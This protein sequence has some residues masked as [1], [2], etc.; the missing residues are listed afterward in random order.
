MMVANQI[1]GFLREKWLNLEISKIR[2]IQE[3]I[4]GLTDDVLILICTN[5]AFFVDVDGGMDLGYNEEMADPECSIENRFKSFCSRL[6]ESISSIIGY[7]YGLKHYSKEYIWK[8]KCDDY[9]SNDVSTYLEYVVSASKEYQKLLN[10]FDLFT[11]LTGRTD[12][13][14]NKYEALIDVLIDMKNEEQEDV[15][16]KCTKEILS[17]HKNYITDYEDLNFEPLHAVNRLALESNMV[18]LEFMQISGTNGIHY[19]P[20]H[21]EAQ[22]NAYNSKDDVTTPDDIVKSVW[23]SG[24][25]APD[26]T[27]YGCPDL[28]HVEFDDELYAVLKTPESEA[29]AESWYNTSRKIESLGY[30][31]LSEGRW[32]L[33]N[34]DFI[35]TKEQLKAIIRCQKEKYKTPKT[36]YRDGFIG[37]DVIECKLNNKEIYPDE[38]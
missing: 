24:W 31:K 36:Y 32:L 11:E 22:E 2:E 37:L 25:L 27:F 12:L 5:Q 20:E 14:L 19:L 10:E 16:D 38:D 13:E 29:N 15:L 9:D 28:R 30:I 4:E 23:N 34:Y 7:A 17:L 1:N 33:P 35:P 8:L 6:K 3:G 26:G 18:A 21:K